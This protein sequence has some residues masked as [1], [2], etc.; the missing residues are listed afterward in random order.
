MPTKNNVRLGG[1]YVEITANNGKLID[2]LKDS[3]SRIQTFVNEFAKTG[4]SLSALGL[5][6]AAPMK[7]AVDT[8]AEFEKQM[9]ITQAVT[10][11]TDAQLARLTK[12]AKDLGATTS[13]TAAQVAEGMVALGRMGFSNREIQG[14]I[15]SVIDL[16]RALDTDVN[17]AAKELG[18]VT[19]LMSVGAFLASGPLRRRARDGDERRR[20]RNGR[21]VRVHEVRRNGGKRDR[22]RR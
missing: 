13:W 7:K 10:K 1:A 20:Y 14:R 3:E 16:G 11:A 22:S 5:G 2:A 9:L 18:A 4:A 8:F 21:T 12:Q 15:S 17:Q 19:P 6:V